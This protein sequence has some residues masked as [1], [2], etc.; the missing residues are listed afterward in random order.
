VVAAPRV[1]RRAVIWLAA[2]GIV[3]AP[4]APG[5]VGRAR[6]DTPNQV[7]VAVLKDGRPFSYQANDG[8][9]KGLAVEMW[10]AI[11]AELRLD[12]RFVSMDRAALLNA[13]ASGQARFGIGPLSITPERLERVDF[14]VPIYTTG[15]VIA[16]PHARRSLWGIVRDSILSTT[17]L[18]LLAGLV[19]AVAV[20]GTI[21]W[22]VERRTNPH[23]AGRPTH[24]WGSGMW[25]SVVT[26]TTVGY[27]DKSPTTLPGRLVAAVW[28]FCGIVLISIFTGTVATLLTLEH[29]GPPPRGFE[30][31]GRARIVSV[32][33]SAAAQLLE[34][35]QLSAQ[36][37]PDLQEAITTLREDRA[38]ALVYD[39][40]L[41]A[42]TVKEIPE[43]RITILPPTLR[44]EFYAIAIHPSEPLRQQLN[45]VIAR[46][47]DSAKWGRWR[48]EYLG[49]S[50]DR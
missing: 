32:R 24:G 8:V 21:L 28:M 23:F 1:V 30:D 44:P 43:V 40:A 29:L 14:S 34:A 22:L 6:A 31:L 9:W 19:L 27:G 46:T 50:E 49:Q 26:M 12:T 36:L 2:A 7:T 33:G 37:V 4:A 10:H 18:Q 38:D 20:M 45:V 15:V 35:R 41:L 25:F 13:V 17:F 42:A 16:V 5:S 48:Y 39:R 3:A 47:L 11:A